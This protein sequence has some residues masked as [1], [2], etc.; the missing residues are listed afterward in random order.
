MG[1]MVQKEGRNKE[2][3]KRNESE[4]EGI[5]RLFL[6]GLNL[7]KKDLREPKTERQN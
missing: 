7:G 2:E 5:I 3:R 6:V 1:K 4:W